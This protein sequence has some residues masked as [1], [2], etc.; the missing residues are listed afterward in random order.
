MIGAK[1]NS[2]PFPSIEVFVDGMGLA[3]MEDA[4]PVILEFVEGKW[5]LHVWS[6]INNEDPTHSVDMSGAFES[7]REEE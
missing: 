3:T 7:L 4:S 6:D 1:L 5:W 2:R